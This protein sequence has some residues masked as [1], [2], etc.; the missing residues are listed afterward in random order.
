[1]SLS[2]LQKKEKEPISTFEWAWF[3]YLFRLEYESENKHIMDADYSLKDDSF[4]NRD[5]VKQQKSMMFKIMIDNH[6]K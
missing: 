3:K 4:H 1:M 5:M 2:K 6:K